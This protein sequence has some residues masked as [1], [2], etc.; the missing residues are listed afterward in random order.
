MKIFKLTSF[1]ALTALALFASCDDGMDYGEQTGTISP[2]VYCDHTVV[3][4]GSRAS[5]IT[6]LTVDDLTLTITSADEKIN[7][8]FS[9]GSFPVERQWPVGKYTLTASYGTDEDEG[10]E[11]PAVY[12]QTE[13]SVSEDKTTQVEL[14]AKPTR[15][16]VGITFDES[17]LNYF[18]DIKA[19]LHSVG[20]RDID[21]TKDETRCA[22]INPGVVTVYVTFTKPNGKG[23]TIEAASFEAKAQYRHNLTLKLGGDGP[24]EVNSL[25]I[26]FDETL[27]ETEPVTIDISDEILTVP[28]PVITLSGATPGEIIEIIEGTSLSQSL[29]FDIKAQ[30]GIRSAVLTTSGESFLKTGWSAEID[31]VNVSEAQKTTLENFGFKDLGILRNPGKIAAF[32]LSEVVKHIPPTVET[33]SP[34]TF[35][36]KVTDKNGKVSDQEPMAVSIKVDKQILNLSIAD[37]YTYDGAQTV[38]IFCEYNGGEPLQNALKL[39]YRTIDGSYE[40]L[41]TFEVQGTRATVYTVKITLPDNARISPSIMIRLANDPTQAIEIT[42][43]TAPELT[44][45]A[46]DVFSTYAIADVT[47]SGYNLADKNYEAQVSTD[48]VNFSTVSATVSGAELRLTGLTPGTAYKAARVKIGTIIS[49]SVSFTTE[50]ASP[51][52]GGDFETWV[53]YYVNGGAFHWDNWQA[54]EGTYWANLNGLTLSKA[55]ATVERSGCE[56]F[57][58]DPNGHNGSC[59]VV[60]TVGWGS[61]TSFNHSNHITAGELFIGSY[62][63]SATYGH[64]FTARPAALK[65]WWKYSQYNNTGNGYV[66]FELLDAGGNV[67]ANAKRTYAPRDSWAPET[68]NF[69]Y[70]RNTAKAATLKL[71]FVS[72]DKQDLTT[73]DV[74]EPGTM[75]MSGKAIGASFYIDDIE[76]VY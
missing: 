45:S 63:S 5:E 55:S 42:A 56:S 51:L 14:T 39:E 32:D 41:T 15:A 28:A 59:G 6:D 76:L 35:A 72:T 26:T 47:T 18:T 12:G 7:E 58:V 19:T 16:M 13:L 8:Q 64:E 4:A 34:I 38:D 57:V 43:I 3:S 27:E 50:N 24:G 65:F 61:A 62:I 36:L 75:A 23:G 33:A 67:I 1:G 37:G 30:G 70:K 11:K 2:N 71:K 68:I 66:E 54:P 20:G 10:F 52:E 29:R 48:G 69:S 53:S 17:A 21:Y 44:L 31:L 60:R 22:Y 25:T 9:A 49:N 74:N 40:P 46:N 73:S